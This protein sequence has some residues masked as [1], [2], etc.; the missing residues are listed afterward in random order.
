MT[1][2]KSLVKVNET[3]IFHRLKN[4]FMN[5]FKKK[6][7]IVVEEETS[8]IIK[9]EPVKSESSFIESIKNMSSEEIAL[10]ELQKIAFEKNNISELSDIIPLDRIGAIKSFKKAGFIHTELVKKELVFGKESI[11]RQ[12]L[13]TKEMYKGSDYYE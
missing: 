8:T 2:E 7:D 5:F 4:F 6:K 12:L 10:L 11:A 1:K 3:N 9:Q 13:I